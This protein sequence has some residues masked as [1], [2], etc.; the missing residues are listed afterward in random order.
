M[1]I[2]MVFANGV[3]SITAYSYLSCACAPASIKKKSAIKSVFVFMEVKFG[4][5]KVTKLNKAIAL[6]CV[7]P[8][9]G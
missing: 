2:A 9:S 4:L 5:S 1:E 6:K 3:K 8:F 7:F